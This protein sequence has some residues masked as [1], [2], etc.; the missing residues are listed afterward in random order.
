VHDV[1]G[2][3]LVTDQQQRDPDEPDRVPPVKIANSIRGGQLPRLCG[4]VG[5]SWGHISI[6]RLT[7][8]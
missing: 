2:A 7:A 5:D 6:T 4:R 3:G 8:N 1:L